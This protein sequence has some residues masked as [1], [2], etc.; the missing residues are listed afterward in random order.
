MLISAFKHSS[1]FPYYLIIKINY[2]S[3]QIFR[4]KIDEKSCYIKVDG[5]IIEYELIGLIY[6]KVQIQ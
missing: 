2:L 1:F 5:T 6:F 4:L 3:P